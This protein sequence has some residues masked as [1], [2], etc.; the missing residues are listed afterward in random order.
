MKILVDAGVGKLSEDWLVTAGHD[1]VSVPALDPRMSDLDILA[2]AEREARLVITMDKD[3]GELVFR[4][5]RG[6]AGVILLR[7]TDA[8]GQQR[9]EAVAEIFTK[10]TA[11]V[12]G[13]F[14]VFKKAQLR[15]R[16]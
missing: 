9:R 15:T 10:H 13:R 4:D 7:L 16:T 8:T 3:F 12:P 14:S 11:T 6:H 5:A 1:V 2:L